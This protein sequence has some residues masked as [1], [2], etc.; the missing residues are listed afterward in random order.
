[1][2]SLLRTILLHT[3]ALYLLPFLVPGVT[4]QGGFVTLIFG[5]ILLTIIAFF[6]RPILNIIT[7]PFNLVTFGIFSIFTNALLL[8]LLTIFV[9]GIII[10]AFTYP[11]TNIFGFSTP[12][13]ELGTFFAFLLTAAILAG[14]INLVQW[15]IN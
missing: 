4:M 14:I 5:G 2:K 15:L 8:Y 1:M 3:G 6:V 13:L 9:P 12:L 7:F 10:K 11:A